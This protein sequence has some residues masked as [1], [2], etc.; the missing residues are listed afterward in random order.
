MSTIF[1][2]VIQQ[3]Y[4]VPDIDDAILHWLER[5]VGPF[6]VEEHI[7][8]P[9]EFDGGPIQADISAAFAYSGDQQIEVIQQF[10]D[11]PTVYAD[12]LATHPE[13]GLH[14]LA[15]WVEDIPKK[16]EELAEGGHDYEVQ[17]RYGDAHAYLQSR[18]HPGVMIQLMARIELMTELFAAIEKA[19]QAWDGKTRPIRKIDWSTGRPV[20]PD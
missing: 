2:P 5:G 16:L 4:V 20:V 3:G 18:S 11:S 9:G 13:G 7:R 19:S 8:P 14:H 10:D 15:V 1:G 6:F 12:F 17:Q